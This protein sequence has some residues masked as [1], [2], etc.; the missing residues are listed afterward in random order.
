[1]HFD[2]N[3]AYRW[4]KVTSF[5]SITHYFWTV[6]YVTEKSSSLR[7]FPEP[8]YCFSKTKLFNLCNWELC[9]LFLFEFFLGKIF[10]NVCTIHDL[11][12]KQHNCIISLV[13]AT[14]AIEIRINQ[15]KLLQREVLCAFSESCS[16]VLT[17]LIPSN[18]PKSFTSSGWDFMNRAEKLLKQ[19]VCHESGCHS[20]HLLHHTTAAHHPWTASPI[21]HCTHTFPSTITPITQLSPITH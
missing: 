8:N 19:H 4:A 21:M 16:A 6:V 18:H 14:W 5:R 20:P 17:S 10:K 3:A 15:I 13:K 2:L 9:N 12:L 11:I 7:F 1:M